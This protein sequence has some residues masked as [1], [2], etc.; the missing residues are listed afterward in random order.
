MYVHMCTH[1]YNR[2]SVS[3]PAKEV[4]FCMFLCMFLCKRCNFPFAIP[5]VNSSFS[6]SSLCA[7]HPYF[8][9]VQWWRWRF[10][11]SEC[12]V[13]NER[14]QYLAG[15]SHSHWVNKFCCSPWLTSEVSNSGLCNWLW[16]HTLFFQLP[17][18]LIWQLKYFIETGTI[19][20]S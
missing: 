12:R 18:N 14:P 11:T 8:S 10:S 5:K 4:N 15:W 6:F 20:F 17:E 2:E 9:R 19:S 13:K 3:W 16:C 7:A 1:A